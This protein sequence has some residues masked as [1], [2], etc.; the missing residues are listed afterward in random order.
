MPKLTKRVV[1]GLK[2]RTATEAFVWDS[3]VKGLG[4]RIKPSGTRSYLIQYRNQARRTRRM[5]LGNCGVLSLEEAR[6][7]AREKLVEVIK[8]E[9]PSAARKTLLRSRTVADLCHWYLAEAESGRLLGR[10]RRPIKASSLKMDRRGRLV[11]LELLAFYA[12]RPMKGSICAEDGV[13]MNERI[14][15][16]IRY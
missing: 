14:A 15:C 7:L 4:I 16:S 8:G 5:V 3:E 2:P 13:V 11:F 6:G 9:D 10:K 1:D 12:V